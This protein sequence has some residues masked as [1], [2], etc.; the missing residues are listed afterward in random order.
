MVTGAWQGSLFDGW[1]PVA[2][3]GRRLGCW[4]LKVISTSLRLCLCFAFVFGAVLVLVLVGVL[5]RLM[6]LGW[7][8]WSRRSWHTS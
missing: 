1:G 8:L 2:G 6:T 7:R 3:A 4:A 5:V